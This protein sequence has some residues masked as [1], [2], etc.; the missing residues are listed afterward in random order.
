MRNTLN[1]GDERRENVGDRKTYI[2]DA[3]HSPRGE[4]IFESEVNRHGPDML[5]NP[6]YG[7]VITGDDGSLYRPAIEVV[8]VFCYSGQQETPDVMFIKILLD[9]ERCWKLPA[10]YLQ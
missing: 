4:H 3:S 1:L 2:P 5:A 9:L 7:H 6:R 10:S 8:N